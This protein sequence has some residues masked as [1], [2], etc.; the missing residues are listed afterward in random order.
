MNRNM[1]LAF[2]GLIAIANAFGAHHALAVE[3]TFAV[4]AGSADLKGTNWAHTAESG[5]SHV[6]SAGSAKIQ[7]SSVSYKGSQGAGTADTITLVPSFAGCTLGASAATVTNGEFEEQCSYQ[8]DSDT[9]AD[10]STGGESGT[11]TLSCPEKQA[12]KA[13]AAGCV[14]SF[15]SQGPLHG[16]EYENEIFGFDITGHV[17]GIKYTTNKAF[18]CMLAGFPASGEGSNGTTLGLTRVKAYETGSSFEVE[19]GVTTP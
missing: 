18:A 16:I 1:L 8:F 6:I 14:V 2:L 17:S 10:P 19:A 13:S 9:T 12:I 7:C 11:T 3:H 4:N 15:S 5:S